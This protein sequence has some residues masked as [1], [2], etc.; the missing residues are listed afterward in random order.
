MREELSGHEDSLIFMPALEVF[1]LE[2]S[3]LLFPLG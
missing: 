2:A 1:S 3:G